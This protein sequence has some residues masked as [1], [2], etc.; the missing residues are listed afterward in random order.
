MREALRLFE[1]EGAVSVKPGLNGGIFREAAGTES[2]SQSLNVFG[3]LHQVPLGDVVEARME[4]EVLCDG[5]AARHTSPEDI[6]RL[7]RLN[8]ECERQ[9]ERGEREGIKAANMAF[10]LALAEA[11]RQG[12]LAEALE[13]TREHLRRFRPGAWAH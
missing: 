13:R 1:R 2:L 9:I 11:V 8:E 10:H 4:L 6:E 3:V 5:M 7:V 12:R